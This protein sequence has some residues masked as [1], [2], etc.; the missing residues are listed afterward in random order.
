MDTILVGKKFIVR[1]DQKA[2]KFLQYQKLHT[3]SQM[4]WIK[5]LMQFHLEIE[6]KKGRVI[7]KWSS[8]LNNY[9]LYHIYLILKV[10]FIHKMLHGKKSLEKSV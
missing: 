10:F 1:I 5:K 8:L 9:D 4:K 7:L 6:Y 3:G 2:L